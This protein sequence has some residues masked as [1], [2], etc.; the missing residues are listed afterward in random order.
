MSGAVGLVGLEPRSSVD[1]DPNGGS[2]SCEVGLGGDSKAVGKS[3]DAGFG[4][5]ED[6]GMIN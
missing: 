3:R 6:L 1:P 2:T 5:G 4:G